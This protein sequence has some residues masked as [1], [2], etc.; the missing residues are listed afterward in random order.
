MAVVAL[1]LSRLILEYGIS[2]NWHTSKRII[3]AA[4]LFFVGYKLSFYAA[5]NYYTPIGMFA[6]T[7]LGGFIGGI[8]ELGIF[9]M[10]VL[11]SFRWIFDK[12]LVLSLK[13]SYKEILICFL[14]G[15]L[16]Q[17]SYVAGWQNLFCV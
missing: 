10:V 6:Y 13:S 4:A 8:V 1:L 5:T 16:I 15:G 17:G 7:F 11:V 14:L 2:L 12:S 3:V 9:S